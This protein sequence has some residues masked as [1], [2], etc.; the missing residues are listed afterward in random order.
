MYIARCHLKEI[1]IEKGYTIREL[2]R[3]SGVTREWIERIEKQDSPNL[4]VSTICKLSNA[5]DINPEEL[6]TYERVANKSLD[7]RRG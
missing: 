1:R 6:I 5:L 7:T 4:R 3:R 2:A